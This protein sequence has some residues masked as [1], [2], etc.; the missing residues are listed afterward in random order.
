MSRLEDQGII[1]LSK[2]AWSSPLV[3]VKKKHGSLHL[4]IDYRRLNSLLDGDSF[5]LPSI[6]E[7]L[8]KV[9]SSV[10]FSCVDLKSGYHQVHLDEVTK[11][12]TALSAGDRLYEYNRLPFGL[13]NAPCHSSKLMAAVLNNLIPTVVLVYLD[14]LIILGTTPEE[15][16]HNLIK[17]LDVLSRH[18]LKINLK[19]CNFFQEK[20]EF[21][22]PEIN[23]EDIRPVFDKIKSIREFPRPRNPKEVSSPLGLVGYYR[24]F[25]RDFMRI[26]RPLDALRKTDKFEWSA[27]AEEA[28][29]T[30]KNKLTSDDIL[31]YPRFER[32]FLVT[33]DASDT[34]LVGVVSQLD[35][36]QRER[37]ISF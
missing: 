37:P 32:P 26:S 19:K 29:E 4:C 8:V 34:A 36:Q 20:V 23:K 31:F 33:C 30:L 27:E 25:I 35:D 5:P 28:F 17:V 6:E 1:T 7:L 13:K 22:G 3:V 10:Y 9:F 15:H 2:S 21:L 18:N 14:G 12:K 16:A 11:H 24:K